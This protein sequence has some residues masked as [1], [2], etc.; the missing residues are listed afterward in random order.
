MALPRL[1]FKRPISFTTGADIVVMTYVE[2][3]SAASSPCN[4][5]RIVKGTRTSHQQNGRCEQQKCADVVEKTHDVQ[6]KSS[7]L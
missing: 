4:I 6:D 7:L 5:V 2:M 3:A 1:T